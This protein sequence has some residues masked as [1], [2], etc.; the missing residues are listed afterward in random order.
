MKYLSKPQ[1][2]SVPIKL[3]INN[4]TKIFDDSLYNNISNTF[5][6]KKS[7]LFAF[8]TESELNSYLN[9]FQQI[10][11]N[12]NFVIINKKISTKNINL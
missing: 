12:E 8:P 10:F 9:H 1:K 2:E 6:H 4:T 7:I 11:N 3:N 5:N